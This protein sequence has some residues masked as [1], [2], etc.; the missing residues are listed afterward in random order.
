MKRNH[1][2]LIS[3]NFLGFSIVNDDG[4]RWINFCS[5]YSNDAKELKELAEKE[6]VWFSTTKVY[7]GV[8]EALDIIDIL[9][10]KIDKL[11]LEKYF[12][13]FVDIEFDVKYC[14]EDNIKNRIGTFR[15]DI[16]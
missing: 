3:A 12:N 11:S 4:H 9:L 8:N 15:Q 13:K 16:I 14:N 6:N 7:G 5:D 10:K 2:R 1:K